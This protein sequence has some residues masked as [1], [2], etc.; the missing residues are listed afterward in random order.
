MMP[1]LVRC[2]SPKLAHGRRF[3]APRHSVRTWG[4]DLTLTEHRSTDRLIPNLVPSC[5][6]TCY[7]SAEGAPIVKDCG[8][9]E[10]IMSEKSLAH[11]S[12]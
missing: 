4:V 6:R 3:T 9:L 12:C 7:H 2:S 11:T 1:S 10:L 8:P 5:L